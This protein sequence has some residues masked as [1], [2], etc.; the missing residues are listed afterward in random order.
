MTLAEPLSSVPAEGDGEIDFAVD[1]AREPFAVPDVP[2]VPVDLV[3]EEGDE[4][5][6]SSRDAEHLFGVALARETLL[7]RGEEETL[8]RQITRARSRIRRV[9]RNARRLS[10]RALGDHSRGVVRPEEDFREREAV[11]ILR[12]AEAALRGEHDAAGVSRAALRTFVAALSTALEEYRVLRDQMVRANVRL[13][14]TL[15]RRYHHPTLTF[16]DLF[17]EGTFGLLR[18]VEKYQP[19][20]GVKFSTYASWWIWQ[21]LGRTA[22][23][24]GDLIRTP[25]H[26]NQLR[27]RAGRTAGDDETVADAEG[28]ASERFATMTQAFHFISTQAHD[29]D[30]RGLES[31][32]AGSIADPET[33][34]AQAALNRHLEGLVAELPAREQLIVR[35]RF[36]FGFDDVNTLEELSRELGV[37]RERVRQ[38]ETRAIGRLRKICAGSGLDDYLR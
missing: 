36:G 2:D 31:V 19:A 30:D 24:K 16:L 17:Q 35:R 12:Y 21:Q 15:A 8:A 7:S 38:L 29:S 23:M 10:R 25:V 4:I 3:D 5:G 34:V 1:L 32:L 9:L 28:I 22:D 33:Q 26:W 37:S 14:A 18:A 27:R 11:A 13:V 20:R 6:A